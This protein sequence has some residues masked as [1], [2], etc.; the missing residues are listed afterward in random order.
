MSHADIAVVRSRRRCESD[1]FPDLRNPPPPNPIA[2]TESTQHRA[3]LAQCKARSQ[4]ALLRVDLDDAD[5]IQPV[6][7]ESGHCVGVVASLAASAACAERIDY[8][9]AWP[10]ASL[11]RRGKPAPE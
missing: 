6:S 11:G 8:A 2:R 3:E 9:R 4:S 10:S 7:P 1:P 5:F